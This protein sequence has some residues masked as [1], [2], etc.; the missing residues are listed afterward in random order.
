LSETLQEI[1]DKLWIAPEHAEWT[2]KTDVL[3]LSD[4]RE[5]IKSSDIEILG[6]THDLIHDGRFRIEPVLPLN[7]Y[8]D[9]VKHYFEL[10]LRDNPEGEWADSS[11]SA[12]GD[13][14]N[15]FASLWRDSSVPREVLKELRNWFGQLYRE[16]DKRVRTCIVNA[17]LEHLFEQK[18]IRNFFADWKN[19]DVL[20]VAHR[21][22]SDWYL[23]G[24]KTPL[25]KPPF[26][27]RKR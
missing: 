13:L 8:K 19:D 14:V 20:A 7:E 16:G 6:F 12:G 27:P 10:C 11:Y 15:I 25:G 1:I 9:F 3:S 5:W 26:V 21:E 23:G 24:G 17:T 18:E 22:A 2:P 4:V